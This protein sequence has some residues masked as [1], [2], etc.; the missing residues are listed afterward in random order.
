V[1]GHHEE[2]SGKVE[3]VE[4][5]DGEIVAKLYALKGMQA[6]ENGARRAG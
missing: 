2:L 5:I 3:F 1:S 4:D 6:G